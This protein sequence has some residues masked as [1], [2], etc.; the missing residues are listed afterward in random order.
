MKSTDKITLDTSV[1][2]LLSMYQKPKYKKSIDL[3]MEHYGIDMISEELIERV[4]KLGKGMSTMVNSTYIKA[5]DKIELQKMIVNAFLDSKKLR[6]DKY[7]QIRLKRFLAGEM[8][9]ENVITFNSFMANEFVTKHDKK[10]IDELCTGEKNYFSENGQMTEKNFTLFIQK[11]PLDTLLRIWK[12]YFQDSLESLT[13]YQENHPNVYMDELAREHDMVREYISVL[14]K[15][16]LNRSQ[17]KSIDLQFNKYLLKRME[18]DQVRSLT[19]V[20]NDEKVS[21]FLRD[22][23]NSFD[24]EAGMSTLT[25]NQFDELAKLLTSTE[26]IDLWA[27]T[28][29]KRY[30]ETKALVM[31]ANQYKQEFQKEKMYEKTK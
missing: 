4:Y 12:V 13:V 22:T 2:L 10:V 21:F 30:E 18:L 15:K 8:H 24:Y 20:A 16:N 3:L 27:Q 1:D 25:P 11:L 14:N 23:L 26:V 28:Y 9:L 6:K 19:K 7:Q 5:L 17:R 31:L 29:D